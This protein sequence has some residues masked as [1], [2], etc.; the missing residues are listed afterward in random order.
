MRRLIERLEHYSMAESM[1]L[2]ATASDWQLNCSEVTPERAAEAV[3][4]IN[5]AMAQAEKRLVDILK[6][7]PKE[8]DEQWVGNHFHYIMGPVYAVM[9]AYRDCGATDTEPMYIAGQAIIDTVKNH[10]GIDNFIGLVD[11]L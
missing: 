2:P 9:Q 10:Y 6:K 1:N 11:Y 8:Y 3:E 5:I 4:E 7:G